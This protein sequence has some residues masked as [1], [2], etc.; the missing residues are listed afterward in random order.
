MRV[1]THPQLVCQLNRT[2][3]LLGQRQDKALRSR[4]EFYEKLM[5]RIV[6]RIECAS[7]IAMIPEPADGFDQD[8]P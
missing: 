7:T 5:E 3:E 8:V 6:A 2:L 1:I 4:D